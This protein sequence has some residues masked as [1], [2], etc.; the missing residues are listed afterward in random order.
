MEIPNNNLGGEPTIVH[1]IPVIFIASMSA[2]LLLHWCGQLP[3]YPTEE[4][5]LCNALDHETMAP[6]A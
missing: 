2:A 5:R 6:S 3:F 4:E 1:G